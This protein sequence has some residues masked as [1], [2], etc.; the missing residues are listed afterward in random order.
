MDIRTKVTNFQ[1]DDQTSAYLDERLAAIE[2]HIG[3]EAEQTRL[4]V[5]VGREAG[6]SQRGDVWFAEIQVRIP[7][8]NYARVKTQ[9]ETVRAAIDEAKDEMLRKLRTQK[10]EHAGFIRKSGAALK[11]MLRME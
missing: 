6:H 7:G 8:G 3:D 1:L 4:E 5:E 9:A 10:R 2:R 11:R